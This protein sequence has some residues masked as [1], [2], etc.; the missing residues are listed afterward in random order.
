MKENNG[1]DYFLEF[2]KSKMQ[3]IYREF[4][5]QIILT[6]GKYPTVYYNGK[7]VLLLQPPECRA[8]INTTG[9]G[10]AFT[11]GLAAGYLNDGDIEE[12]IQMGHEY[13]L[14]NCLSIRPGFI[15][16]NDLIPDT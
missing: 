12:A 5:S 11:A 15:C 7:Q 8:P 16:F 3:D 13:A 6:R 4:G 1:D 2:V 9:C 14:K 10:D